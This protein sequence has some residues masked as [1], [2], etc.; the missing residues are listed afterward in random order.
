MPFGLVLKRAPKRP[1]HRDIGAGAW[2]VHHEKVRQIEKRPPLA[3]ALDLVEGVLA[4]EEIGIGLAPGVKLPK[5]FD[6]IAGAASPDLDV[7]DLEPRI[8]GRREPAHRE[9]VRRRREVAR[10]LVGR[11][12]ARDEEH[13]AEARGLDGFLGRAQMREMDRVE[14]AAEEAELAQRARRPYSR[15]WPVPKTTNLRVVRSSMP[16]GP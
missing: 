7:R 9:A 12:G 2:A 5:R 16:M 4:D 11:R 8:G 14:G 15:T 10:P 13:S 1:G 6:G 3:P